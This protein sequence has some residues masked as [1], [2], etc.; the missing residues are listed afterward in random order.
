MD[1]DESNKDNVLKLEDYKL[2]KR[3]PPS[4]KLQIWEMVDF[5]SDPD[6]WLSGL[7]DYPESKTP[8]IEDS[9]WEDSIEDKTVTIEDLRNLRNLLLILQH[10]LSI[11]SDN[12][13]VWHSGE[14]F[15]K[16]SSVES[17]LNS[18]LQFCLREIEHLE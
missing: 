8:Y 1:D 2:K 3:L 7:E 13:A 17:N 18:M 4:Q 5:F 12:P 11:S 9:I 10:V 14:L 16:H 15:A 6:Y